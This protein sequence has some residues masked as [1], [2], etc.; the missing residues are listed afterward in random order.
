LAFWTASIAS[1]RIALAIRVVVCVDFMDTKDQGWE[2]GGC[3]AAVARYFTRA[4]RDRPKAAP[5]LYKDMTVF[6]RKKARRQGAGLSL[7]HQA[8]RT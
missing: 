5:P 7:Q 3:L 4:V 6:G 2:G 8:I 1:A